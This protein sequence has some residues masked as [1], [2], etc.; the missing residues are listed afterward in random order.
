MGLAIVLQPSFMDFGSSAPVAVFGALL[1]ASA[2]CR[3]SHDL[4]GIGQAR[5]DQTPEEAAYLGDGERRQIHR[6]LGGVFS[7]RRPPDGL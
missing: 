1:V 4:R 5:P 6:A 3:P 2:P 7:P